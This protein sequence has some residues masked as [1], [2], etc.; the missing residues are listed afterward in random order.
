MESPK[1]E[2]YITKYAGKGDS[3]VAKGYPKSVGVGGEAAL[4]CGREAAAL[5]L[6][7]NHFRLQVGQDQSG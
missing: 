4:D 2:K 5:G 1:L 6:F 3:E 7:P